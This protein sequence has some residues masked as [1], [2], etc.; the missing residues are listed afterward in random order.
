MSEGEYGLSRYGRMDFA[1]SGTSRCRLSG[2]AGSLPPRQLNTDHF[3]T[4]VHSLRQGKPWSPCP[5]AGSRTI[6]EAV[7]FG[8]T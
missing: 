4:G 6:E 5:H 3:D 8:E 7:V 1:A 2:S